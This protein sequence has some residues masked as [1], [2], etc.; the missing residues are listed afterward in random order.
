MSRLWAALLLAVLMLGLAWDRQLQ[1][2]DQLSSQQRYRSLL[3]EMPDLLMQPGT[4]TGGLE[5]QGELAT[6]WNR[7]YPGVFNADLARLRQQGERVQELVTQGQSV[8]AVQLLQQVVRP[9]AQALSDQLPDYTAQRS[10][11]LI[12]QRGLQAASLMLALG[13]AIVGWTSARSRPASPLAL[14]PPIFS[15]PLLRA[16]NSLLLVVAPD[17]KIQAVNQAACEAL[18]Y[19][20]KELVG[21]PFQEIYCE[22]PDLLTMASCRD[23][24]G[25]YRTRSGAFFPVV[26]AC[27]VVNQGGR[28]QALITLAQDVSQQQLAAAHLESSESRLRA[29]LDRFVGAQEEERRKVAR[30]VHDGLLQY[31]VAAQLQLQALA[32]DLSPQAA[33]PLELAR[34]HLHSAVDE[35]RRLIQNLR[36]TALAELGLVGTLRRL[37]E[38]SGEELGWEVS[39]Q[40]NLGDTQLSPSLETTLYRIVQEALSNTRKHA[41]ARFVSLQL[42]RHEQMV[43]L[44]YQDSGSGFEPQEAHLGVGLE[45]M[46]ERAELLGGWLKI[47][48]APA[49]GTTIHAGIPFSLP[50][51]AE[52]P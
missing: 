31:I 48:S 14:E 12:W 41:R 42:M 17:G 30:D 47:S 24:E 28:V 39:L 23:L 11:L 45:S 51:P 44:E 36:P 20:E 22:R 3:K 13:M 4:R 8:A 6:L 27:S 21:M 15:Q 16:M 50:T 46:R 18:G 10:R 7:L 52:R 1:F 2:L 38:E 9:A 43:H 33:Q 35:G 19:A 26:M 5:L 29:L 49:S 37:L 40:E 34:T 32:Y 25:V